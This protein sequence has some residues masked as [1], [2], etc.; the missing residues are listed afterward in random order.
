M[1]DCH[2]VMCLTSPQWLP[3]QFLVNPYEYWKFLVTPDSL[4]DVTPPSLSPFPWKW[5]KKLWDENFSEGRFDMGDVPLPSL[6]WKQKKNFWDVNFS[7]VDL[8]WTMYSP[9]LPPLETK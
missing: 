4:Y 1:A 8:T 7:K 2:W 6:P 9:S 3:T 5:G